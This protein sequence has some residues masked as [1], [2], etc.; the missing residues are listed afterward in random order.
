MSDSSVKVT[1]RSLVDE[2]Y[3]KLQLY[4]KIKKQ[5]GLLEHQTSLQT[6]K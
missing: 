4:G 1:V 5:F 2:D 6:R 3:L